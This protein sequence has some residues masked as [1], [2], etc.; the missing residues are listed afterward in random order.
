LESSDGPLWWQEIDVP[1]K[2]LDVEVP[3]NKEWAR[4]DLYWTSVV[5]R[6]GDTSKQATVKRAV[7]ILHLPLQDNNRRIDIALDA[8]EKIRPNQDL[9]IRI[10]AK[11]VAGQPLPENINVLVSAV[12][13]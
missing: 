6:P 8:P 2:G 10:K 1:E 5:V 7:G 12:D 11:P 4:H 9:K 3:I 13:T